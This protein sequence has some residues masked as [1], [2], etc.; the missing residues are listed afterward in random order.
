[1]VWFLILQ[2]AEL[3]QELKLRGLTVSGTKNDLIERLR[4]YQ[5]Q[6]G[7]TTTVLKNGIC[8][9]SQQG[10]TSAGSGITSSPTTTNTTSDHQSGE[11]GFKLNLSSLAQMVPGRVMRFGSTSSSPPVSPTPS[12]RSLAGMS[13]DETSCNG[14]MFGEM[15]RSLWEANMLKLCL[16]A[17]SWH[18]SCF[19]ILQV[20][21]PLTQL[22][23]H[24]SPQHPSNLSP[25]SQA[26][27]KVKEEIQSSC[28]LSRVSPAS[29][30]PPESLP[31]VAM[32]TMDKDQML[33]EKDKQIEELTRMLRQK[34]RLVETLRSQLEQG[35][36]AGGIVLEKEGSEKSKSSPDVK[37]QTLIKASAIQPP[38]LPNGTVVTV[39]KEV[40]PEEGMEGVTEEAQVKKAA[41]PM[42]CSQ[43]TLLRLQQIH[44]L[45][46]QQAEQQK[47][48]LLQSQVQL[49][50][51]AELKSNPQK[52]Q[53]Q[54]KDAQILLH[55]QQQLQQLIIQ[56]TQQKQLQAQQKLAQ[57]RLAQQKLSQQ[58]LVQQNQLKQ[59]QGPVQQS[60]QKSQVQLK[61]VQVQI[62]KPAVS[63]IQQRKHL[64][65]QQRQ[66]HRQQTAAVTTQQVTS[67]QL[68]I[69]QQTGNAMTEL[70]LHSMTTS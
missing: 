61:Q 24:P 52:L 41:Q 54:K 66:Q 28:S 11:C 15:V 37:L 22:T 25:L 56:Q 50:K 42:Q 3:K 17:F 70:A 49:Q 21:S 45:Q 20:S 12:E 63:Q 43:E 9:Q 68:H 16:Q 60:Q 62:Q 57:Q 6:N 18:L 29:C 53:Q 4:N 7:A 40:E 5:E 47:Q 23:L 59:T 1:M 64:K 13:P 2:V 33:Q 67:Q 35:K 14:D 8:Q 19:V 34:Q 39:K 44:R 27:S 65:A 26:L 30:Q 69:T 38:T 46:V 51:V 48:T 10:T 55:Q 36:M 58:K 31:G 32:D